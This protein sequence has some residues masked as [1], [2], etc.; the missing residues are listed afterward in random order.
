MSKTTVWFVVAGLVY[1][2]I[3]AALG[4]VM[5]IRPEWAI[6]ASA[7]GHLMALGFIGFTVF[8]VAYHIL[9][10]F[11]GQPLHSESLGH[12]HLWL[13]N[14]GVI[15]M[16]VGFPGYAGTLLGQQTPVLRTVFMI[17]AILQL[18]GMYLF[19]YNLLRTLLPTIRK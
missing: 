5:G 9:P 17:G 12:L 8:G 2:V 4:L 18:V 7:H 16:A 14:L 10:R 1:L 15:G 19:V 3:G 11:A 6:W 13:A